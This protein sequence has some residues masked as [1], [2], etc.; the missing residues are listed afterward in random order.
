M[1]GCGTLSRFQNPRSHAAGDDDFSLAFALGKE[2]H[3]LNAIELR[4]GQ[5]DGENIGARPGKSLKEFF[6]LGHKFGFK[7]EALGD[8]LDGLTDGRIIVEDEN[9]SAWHWVL[10]LPAGA[11]FH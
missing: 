3:N 6:R 8:P 10:P 11:S 4:H 2:P 7:T 9:A 5:I 1:L